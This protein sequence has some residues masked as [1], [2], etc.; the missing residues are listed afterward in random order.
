LAAAG[1]LALAACSGGGHAASSASRSAAVASTAMAATATS[2]SD[3]AKVFDTNCSSCHGSNGAGSPGAFPPLAGNPVVVGDPMRVIH[4]VK[5]G[6]IGKI[7][8]AGQTYNGEMPKWG[9]VLSAGD[10]A[11]AITYIRSAWG[12][13]ASPVTVAQVTAQK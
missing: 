5:D 2:A 7:V 3:G 4:I 13:K 10:I 6:L 11:S 9:S 8:I 12:N 1:S